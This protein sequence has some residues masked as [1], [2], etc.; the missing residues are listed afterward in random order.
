M[1]QGDVA[2]PVVAKATGKTNPLR[3]LMLGVLSMGLGIAATPAAVCGLFPLVT[4]AEFGNSIPADSGGVFVVTS[5]LFVASY[6]LLDACWGWFEERRET[7]SGRIAWMLPVIVV[8]IAVICWWFGS[9]LCSE[10]VSPAEAIAPS[11]VIEATG[12]CYTTV[13]NAHGVNRYVV[14]LLRGTASAGELDEYDH[15]KYLS[16]IAPSIDPE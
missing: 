4:T 16:A 13:K 14:V 9:S 3:M 5:T 15:C 7:S 12:D 11:A 10:D 8:A 1:K 6:K 2:E